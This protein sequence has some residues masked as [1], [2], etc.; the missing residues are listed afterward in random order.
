LGPLQRKTPVARALIDGMISVN[1]A[2]RKVAALPD[3]PLNF[4]GNIR[5]FEPGKTDHER[6]C[7]HIIDYACLACKSETEA[8]ELRSRLTQELQPSL[9]QEQDVGGP[10]LNRQQPK[11][12]CD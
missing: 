9:R 5:Q 4:I 8:E 10:T 3:P 1:E 11:G 7:W 12:V 6:L 2:A